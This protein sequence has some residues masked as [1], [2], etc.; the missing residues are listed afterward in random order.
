MLVSVLIPSFN[1]QSTVVDAIR[2]ALA[3]SCEGQLE[4]VV[5][6]DGSTDRTVGIVEQ[7]VRQDKRVRILRAVTNRGSSHAR[8]MLLDE[9]RGDWIAFLDA[10]DVFL[11]SKLATCLEAAN[12]HDSDFVTHDLGYLR[13]DDEVVGRI[14]SDGFLQGSLLRRYLTEGLRFSETLSAGEDSQ[15]LC[16]LKRKARHFHLSSVL[17]GI[18]IRRGSLTDKFWFQKRLIELWHE[19]HKDVPPPQNIDGYIEFYHSLSIAER[20]GNNRRWLGQKFGR[21]AAGAVLAG[22]RF[23]AAYYLLGSFVLNPS[24]LL[25]R[26]K[27]NRS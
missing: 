14:R 4:I 25:S 17:T 18:R 3:Q 15:F 23:V 19:R 10:D 21:S 16:L 13:A 5:Y 24:Y 27:N 6:D 11:P 12:S 9:A 2:S 7:W 20:L 22:N 1:V 26:L 8:N